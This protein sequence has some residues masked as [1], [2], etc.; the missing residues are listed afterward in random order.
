MEILLVSFYP[1]WLPDPELLDRIGAEVTR[2]H[3]EEKGG[4]GKRK[5]REIRGCTRKRNTEK[6]EQKKKKPVKEREVMDA[7]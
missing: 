4:E 2:I 1:G 3:Q 7:E 5:R 6:R